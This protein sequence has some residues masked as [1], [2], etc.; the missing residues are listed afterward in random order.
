MPDQYFNL[1]Y[2]TCTI[3]HWRPLLAEDKY[4]ELI[5]GAFQ[6]CKDHSRAKIWAFVIMDNHFHVV[7]QILEPYTLAYVQ[8]NLLK[9]VSQRIIN[10]LMRCKKDDIMNQYV[11]RKKDRHIQ[12]WKRDPLSVELISENFLWQKINYIHLNRTRKGFS[13]VDYK[14]SSASY[15]ATGVKNWDFLI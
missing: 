11:V 14:Y 15:Y 12:I 9:F 5:T 8:R 4:K 7:W 1:F 2:T 3:V 13:D 6:F 10:D